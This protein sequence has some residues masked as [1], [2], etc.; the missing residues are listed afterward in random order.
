MSILQV[1]YYGK[2]FSVQYRY[3][4]ELLD[5]EARRIHAAMAN[6]EQLRHSTRACTDKDNCLY[7][8]VGDNPK[9]DIRGANNAGDNW[10]SVLVRTG[11]FCSG[12]ANDEED[13]ADFVVAD[14]KEAV[15]LIID[16]E[17]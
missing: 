10:R 9:S 15:K 13:P 17:E 2:P 4:S 3:A 11:V 12:S 6:Q 5:L 8:G 1:E 16:H 7:F 14:L